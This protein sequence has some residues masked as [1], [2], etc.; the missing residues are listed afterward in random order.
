[1]HGFTNITIKRE[2]KGSLLN[3]CHHCWFVTR[4]TEKSWSN[5]GC[6]YDYYFHSTSN[7]LE[8][9]SNRLKP[10]SIFFINIWLFFGGGGGGRLFF[11]HLHDLIYTIISGFCSSHHLLSSNTATKIMFQSHLSAGEKKLISAKCHFDFFADYSYL[12]I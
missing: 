10:L 6:V 3:S 9:S 8:R 5:S 7:S 12:C 11:C 1:M 4:A 2:K